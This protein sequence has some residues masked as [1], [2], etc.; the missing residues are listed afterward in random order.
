LVERK[1]FTD[2]RAE[3]YGLI[4][5]RSVFDKADGEIFLDWCHVNKRGNFL[6]SQAIK[7]ALLN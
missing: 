7:K 1:I 3:L 6:V 2:S 5:L 4:D